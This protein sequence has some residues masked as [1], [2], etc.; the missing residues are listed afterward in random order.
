M[1]LKFV[2]GQGVGILKHVI[3]QQV[4][5][6]LKHTHELVNGLAVYHTLITLLRIKIELPCHGIYNATGKEIVL[7]GVRLITCLL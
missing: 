3:T 6:Q 5:T 1:E 7:H 4:T 2:F